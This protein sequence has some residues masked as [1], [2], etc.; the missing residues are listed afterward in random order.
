MP[1]MD[2]SDV[3]RFSAMAGESAPRISSAALEVKLSMPAMGPYSW[4]SS[5]LLRRISS[6]CTHAG[7]AL[8]FAR[9]S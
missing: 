9:R 5:G 6:A 3:E 7:S 4:L 1:E 2:W 8:Q